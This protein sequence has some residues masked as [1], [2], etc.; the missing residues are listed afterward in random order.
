MGWGAS[1]IRSISF[2]SFDFGKNSERM[3]LQKSKSLENVF[4][5]SPL[6][7]ISDSLST[8]SSTD[9]SFRINEHFNF[10]KSDLVDNIEKAKICQTCRKKYPTSKYKFCS[11][12]CYKKSKQDAFGV[13]H[14]KCPSCYEKFE[15]KCIFTDYCS[16]EC[17]SDFTKNHMFFDQK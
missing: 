13:F 8:T 9:K 1:L 2:D 14:L 11:F 6:S 4:T 5:G 10:F 7:G 3:T 17:F 15:T 16:L 12:Q